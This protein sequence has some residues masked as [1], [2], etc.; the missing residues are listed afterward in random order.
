M[1]GPTLVT[2]ATGFIGAELAKTLLAR[3]ERVRVIV[4]SATGLEAV[5]L[6]ARPGLE[7]VVGDLLDAG[8]VAR[9]LAGVRRVHH[10]A[11]LVST[12]RRDERRVW[13]ANHDATLTLLAGVE[14]A[15][16]ERVVYLASIFA[17][18]G[19]RDRRPVA[20]DVE[21][22]LEDLDVAY[23]QAKRKAE[24][25]V[26]ALRDKGL[27]VV[28]V[29]PCFCYGPGDVRG[30]SSRLVEA[31]LSG[32][33]RVAMPG[34]QNAMDVRDAAVALDR[35]MRRGR[36]G[37][38][39]IVG[40]ENLTYREL[41]TRLAR[42]SGLSPPA[43][44][45]PAGLAALAGRAAERLFAEP[46]VDEG[47]ALLAGRFWYYDDSKARRELGHESRPV[48]ETLEDS[49]AWIRR[50]RPRRRRPSG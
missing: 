49:V 30:S 31:H 39:Y 25:H 34:G 22:D 12:R 44:T 29:Y 7:V 47:A 48:E 38:R 1:D 43:L 15:E 4:R 5:G 50:H 37:E 26:L 23:V 45:L 46:L 28:L 9:A 24:L 10:V 19:G 3:G 27:P 8:A 2:G 40:G 16:V 32:L 18:G 13:R 41:G 17:L 11:G 6:A 42:I 20:E 33:L 14:Q 36:V 21:W 35:A